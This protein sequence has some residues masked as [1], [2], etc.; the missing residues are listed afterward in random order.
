M[1]QT[2]ILV[3]EDYPITRKMI[4][5]ALQA[6]DFTVLEA[7]TAAEA[8]AIAS[9]R[10]PNL[11]LQ[12][13]GLPDM[14]GLELQR[15]L[16]SLPGGSDV[17][18]L[19]C[20]GR[21]AGPG[22]QRPV[23]QGFDDYLVK[24]VE[25]TRLIDVVRAHLRG[26]ERAPGRPGENRRVLLVD[27]N[28]IQRKIARRRMEELGFEV[29]TAENGVD[30]L[31]KARSYQPAAILTDV[32][33]PRLDGFQLCLCV[34]RDPK[35]A[36]I[37]VLLHSAAYIT[38]ED[39]QLARLVGAY[40][41]FTRTPNWLD[42][43]PILTAAIKAGA[44]QVTHAFDETV[45]AA[46]F[47]R[48][49]WQ[50]ETQATENLN[51]SRRYTRQST[52]LTLL[53]SVSDALR[54]SSRTALPLQDVLKHCLDAAGV[55]R[56]AI[57]QIMPTGPFRVLS[58]VGLADVEAAALADRSARSPLLNNACHQGTALSISSVDPLAE[59]IRAL[60]ERT[61]T[62]SALLVPIRTDDSNSA[63]VLWLISPGHDFRDADWIDFARGLSDHL[64]QALTLA[65]AF[66]RITES[67]EKFRQLVE[68][69][70]GIVWEADA[71]T[72]RF[73]YVSPCA[74]ALLGYPVKRWLN[75]PLFFQSILHPTEHNQA[76]EEA[77]RSLSGNRTY[78][79]EYCVIA[80][81]GRTVWL[82][83]TVRVLPGRDGVVKRL[84]GMMVDI[85]DRKRIEEERAE[86]LHLVAFAN[87]V[88]SSLASGG[89]LSDVLNAC[90]NATISRL[91]AAVVRIYTYNAKSEML[92]HQASAGLLFG[93]TQFYPRI[94]LGKYLIGLVAQLRQPYMT[95]DFLN[96]PRIADAEWARHNGITAFAGHPMIVEDRLVG[97]LMVLSCQPLT[98]F[99]AQALTA[100]ASMIAVGVERLLAEERLIE[101]RR[102][103]DTFTKVAPLA[104]YAARIEEGQEYYNTAWVSDSILR[105]SGFSPEHFTSD[106]A[107]WRSRIHPEDRDAV[108]LAFSRMAELGIITVE[109]RWQCA[110]G[111]YRYFLD[112]ATLVRDAAGK[113]TEVL[114]SWLDVTALHE[115]EQAL[116]ERDEQ[117]RQTQKLD[118][119]GR[120]AG[121]VAHDFNNLLSVILVYSDLAL[122]TLDPS[123]PLHSHISEMKAAG[124][125]AANLTRQLLAFSRRQ[126]LEP[127]SL[128]LNEVVSGMEKMLRRVI[129]ED[130]QLSIESDAALGCVRADP[131]Q[132]EQVLLNLVINARDAMPTG[133]SLIIRTAN[134][135]IDT[136]AAAEGTQV[137]PGE[138]V[139]LS[140]RDTGCG[141]SE[142]V[143][144]RLFE[145]FFTTKP[146]GQGTGLGLSTVYGIVQQSGGHIRVESTP[147]KGSTFEVFLPRTE[148]VQLKPAPQI[149]LNAQPCTETVLLVEDEDA[150]RR[151][152]SN[153]LRG[154]GYTVLEAAGGHEALALFERH[155]GPIHLLLTDVVMPSMSGRELADRLIQKLPSL[156]MLYV[157]GYTDDSVVRHGL[158]QERVHLLQKPFTPDD[159]L[160][161]VRRALEAPPP[162][163]APS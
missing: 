122:L 33:M 95:N 46:Y 132:F 67:E 15:R 28:P 89:S 81:D 150:V 120:L 151:I 91:N 34:R 142:A 36:H 22:E 80:A 69:I 70:E 7:G 162:Q 143:R 73:T 37:P 51:L 49:V 4:R 26:V 102:R 125:R 35:L 100:T 62:G 148:P 94:P 60:F 104:I 90:C 55:S 18:I 50:L 52:H 6:E 140:V 44:P 61:N 19:A 47:K 85:T 149:E 2:T 108:K 25:P 144:S 32:L 114:G 45:D 41:L 71:L 99:A 113:P 75:D 21:A 97:V 59:D 16:R 17:L 29:E 53:R 123:D 117:I 107:H 115:A 161:H 111:A 30:A 126:V 110:D 20:S 65:G 154:R 98:A 116:H 54:S 83:D 40:S 68:S 1:S 57:L 157:S 147:G 82:H 58:T 128:N 77:R 66:A 156:R 63:K 155:Q 88:A 38:E 158:Q 146:A 153:L 136:A 130:I 13:L 86:R 10:M 43:G 163:P 24:P 137:V 141:M 138:Y 159:L 121:G 11:V 5:V 84:R 72:G 74:E 9:R 56:G 48:V 105:V 93:N 103:L 145:P 109:Y 87:E 129:G 101:N 31:G 160:A 152:I 119:I 92:E 12:D 27:D 78:S 3:I 139:A 79:T 64:G 14:D 76:S 118:S 133:G 106:V 131:G 135:R 42:L 39:T 112:Q 8:L 96:D 23:P 124:Q 134:L 127:R